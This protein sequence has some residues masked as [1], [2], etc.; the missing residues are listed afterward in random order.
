MARLRPLPTD[1]HTLDIV[2]AAVLALAA[3]RGIWIGA[4]REAFSL[5][6]LAA[7]AFVVRSWRQPAAA[8]LDA[9]GPFEVTE[10][11]AAIL[12]ALGLGLGTLLAVGIAGRL[13]RRGVRGAGLGVV[14]R[15][16]GG[17]LGSA[18]GAVVMA[19]FV[20]GLAALL[21]REDDALA[22]TR[23]LAALEALESALGTPRPE[24]T[25]ELEP[26][27]LSRPAPANA[28]ARE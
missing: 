20:L 8:W 7:A 6:G 15:L 10:L 26:G 16:A 5:A 13:V 19:A 4:V 27:Q 2:A 9:H 18:E 23:S 12:A 11:A 17:L 25:G 22:G 24:A 14:D 1:L 3:L 21:G 28:H